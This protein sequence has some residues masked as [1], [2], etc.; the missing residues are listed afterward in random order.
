M[1]YV[2]KKLAVYSAEMKEETT[3]GTLAAP[4][5]ADDAFYL[6]FDSDDVPEMVTEE[7]EFDGNLGPNAVG[8]GPNLQVAPSGKA[9]KVPLSCYFRGPGAAYA[10]GVFAK[11][12]WHLAMKIAG[13]VP[14]GDFTA[15]SE[16]FTFVQGAPSVTPTSAS[17]YCWA[18][19]LLGEAKMERVAVL[20]ALAN[21]KVMAQDP[22]P[23]KWMFEVAGIY[24][25]NPTDE[26]FTAPTLAA[27]PL[28][29]LSSATT[30]EYGA[31]TT[32]VVYGWEFDLGRDISSA[33]VPLNNA[34]VHLGFVAGGYVPTMSVTIEQTALA[35][36][37]PYAIRDAAGT[38][39][40]ELVCGTVQYNRFT[41]NGPQA[42]LVE[43]KQG[44]RGKIPTWT[45]KFLLPPSTPAGT[46]SHNWVVD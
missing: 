4:A 3:F 15:S 2:P 36:W 33:R 41:L 24:S 31:F 40:L 10:A 39:A 29:P 21:L 16:K 9:A 22:K 14:T 34:G 35:T 19:Q 12:R 46:D 23:A 18:K 7:F 32:A 17:I 5:A 45:L 28:P 26:T 42:Q 20:A 38:A 11:N 25:G 30:F 13:Y 8:Y 6:Q 43:V 1:A 44:N 27:T 37:N